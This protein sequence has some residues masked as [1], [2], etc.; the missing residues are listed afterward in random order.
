MAQT[1]PVDSAGSPMGLYDAEPEGEARGA[2]V[3]QEA[4]GLTEHIE[5]GHAFH[6]DARDDTHHEAS[7]KDGW[8][9]TLDWFGT[10]IAG[11]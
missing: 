10:H 9:R 5:A 8:V 11:R 7:A 6:C 3:V 4:F 2:V 1:V